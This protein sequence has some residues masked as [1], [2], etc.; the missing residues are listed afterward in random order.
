M[1]DS[2]D[3]SL[4]EEL[5]AA[6]DGLKESPAIEGE[7][8]EAGPLERDEGGRF[9]AK[10]A[11]EEVAE[12]T[13][14]ES[15]P[16]VVEDP[17]AGAAAAEA[18]PDPYAVPPTSADKA[19]REKW[20]ELPPEVREG[21]HRRE[22]DVHKGFTKW[23]EERNF[24]KRV[25]EVVQPF[26]GFIKSLGAEPIQAVDYL[27]KTDYALRT[28]EPNAR[29]QM[30]LKA[31][32]DYGVDLS[33]LTQDAA[34]LQANHDPVVETLQQRIFRLENQLQNDTN[35]R[36]ESEQEQISQSIAD[37]ASKPEHVHFP[38]VQAMMAT[39][40]EAG[41]ADSLEKAYDMAVLADPETRAL[42]LAAQREAEDRKRTEAAKAKAEAA[43][44][45]S[46]SVTGAPGSA[47]PTL[48][49]ESSG[50][51]E[52]DIRNAIRAAEGRV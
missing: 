37:F 41:H 14:V 36:R 29:A 15:A 35:A 2:P 27:I 39:L 10:E 19:V 5:R 48:T 47:V 8:V 24:G 3:L 40:M 23:D 52:D 49:S 17:A 33:L 44:K 31:A 34:N 38:R 51:L 30:F 45:A 46:V 50:S 43:R 18:A 4:E 20:A 16:E 13:P 6:M 7:V 22:I 9:K 26:E 25:R 12:E 1:T 42:H 11:T 28:A 32:K 21:I